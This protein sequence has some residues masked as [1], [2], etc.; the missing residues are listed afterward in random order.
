M[1]NIK[2]NPEF[3]SLIPSLS[4]EEYEQLESS[5][6]NEGLR[7]PICLCNEYII[8]GHN[9]YKIC[10]KNNIEIKTREIKLRED[11]IKSWVLRNQL[12][13]RNLTPQQLSILR[14]KLYNESKQSHGGQIRGSGHFDHSKTSKELKEKFNVGEKTIRRDASFVNDLNVIKNIDE[15]F[16]KNIESENIKATK[17]EINQLSRQP[18]EKAKKIINKVKD[19]SIS[20]SQAT[21]EVVAK[22][23]ESKP[24]KPTEKKYQ[25]IYSDPPWDYN[26]SVPQKY[27]DVGKHYPSMSQED[28]CN[29]PVSEIADKNCVLFLW[30]T[31]PK[32]K[33]GLEVIERWGFEYKTS[34]VW[35]KVK[36][37]IGYYNSVRHEFL[38]IAGKGSS[39]PTMRKKK[40]YDSVVS[41]ERSD[42][43]SEKPEEF[44]KIIEELYPYTQKIELFARKQV[45]G[46]DSFGNEV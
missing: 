31:S 26:S 4:E 29:M 10:N 36:N 46:W 20:I 18:K 12:S 15:K 9:R 32:L 14:G 45:E 11:E 22:E 44:R 28:L 2:I 7:D 6:C 41:I 38:L 23:L 3:E 40:L 42:K 30:V 1:K 21:R 39:T 16:E 8:D 35:D 5:I 17:N 33:E 34:F 24:L 27:G 19:D 25:V 13:R 43:H 37:N